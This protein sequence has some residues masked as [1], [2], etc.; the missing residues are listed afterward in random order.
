MYSKDGLSISWGKTE[1]PDIT[2]KWKQIAKRVRQLIEADRY[3]SSTEKEQYL[4]Y[5]REK[6]AHAARLTIGTAFLRIGIDYNHYQGE[7][8]KREKCFN[9][10]L[11]A[12]CREAFIDGKKQIHLYGEGQY[13]LPL[14]RETMQRIIG[15]D[16]PLTQRCEAMLAELNGPL[17]A[18]LEPDTGQVGYDLGFGY[19]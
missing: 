11:F 8:G 16:T 5:L 7:H 6:E 14:M 9:L 12:S 17:V 2:L 13:T 1:Q 4:V 3:L 18:P 10:Q 15:E 19:T